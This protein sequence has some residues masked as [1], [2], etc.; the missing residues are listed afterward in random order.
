MTEVNADLLAR[1]RAR[2][3]IPEIPP[4]RVCGGQ[5][6]VSRMGGGEPTIFH[7]GEPEA[8]WLG[9]DTICYQVRQLDPSHERG[10]GRKTACEHYAHYLDS[11][12]RLYAHG[13]SDV[14]ALIDY[15]ESTVPSL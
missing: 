13:D 2:Y 15:V 7:C 4:C 1:L 12:Y 5:L 10:W 11:E 3:T 6:T 9:S 14:L 8:R